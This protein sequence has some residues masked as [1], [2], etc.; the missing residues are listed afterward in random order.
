[1]IFAKSY[2][3]SLNQLSDPKTPILHPYRLPRDDLYAGI[4]A[5]RRSSQRFQK[6]MKKTKKAV[7]QKLNSNEIKR[8]QI[9]QKIIRI[10]CQHKKN[11]N[12]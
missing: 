7:K 1:M 11:N 6:S 9:F 5:D 3:T 4:V 2:K 10:S 12:I 8:V